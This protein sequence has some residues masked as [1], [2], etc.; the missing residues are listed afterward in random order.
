MHLWYLP[1]YQPKYIFTYLPVLKNWFWYIITVFKE[2]EKN[3][4]NQPMELSVFCWFFHKNYQ[5]LHEK[6]WVL[7]ITWWFF[8]SD[9]F[10]KN[11]NQWFFE[12][13][14][15]KELLNIEFFKI[16][17]KCPTLVCNISWNLG[18]SGVIHPQE[19]HS[20][21]ITFD[22]VAIIKYNK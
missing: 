3:S 20:T 19:S 8:D 9:F 13:Q 12:S 14:I 5:F 18:N 11:W 1:T 15:F 6:H 10:S 16:L 22:D 2:K 4:N 7:K 21:L 17:K